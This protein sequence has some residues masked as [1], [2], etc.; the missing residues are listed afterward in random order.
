MIVI[1]VERKKR[2]DLCARGV[3]GSP[4]AFAAVP[5]FH[6]SVHLSPKAASVAVSAVDVGLFLRDAHDQVRGAR[7]IRGRS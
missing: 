2:Q 4:H 6:G 1:Q 5:I 7:V 3:A